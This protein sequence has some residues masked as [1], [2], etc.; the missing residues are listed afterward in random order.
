MKTLNCLSETE[1]MIFDDFDHFRL[2][3]SSVLTFLFLMHFLLIS[4]AKKFCSIGVYSIKNSK[5]ISDP[6]GDFI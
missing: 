6:F 1:G 4:N 2:Y 3:V 5:T